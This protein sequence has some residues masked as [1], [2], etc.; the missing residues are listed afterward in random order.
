MN[1]NDL[2]LQIF[3]NLTDEEWDKIILWLQADPEFIC[4]QCG[5]EHAREVVDV[6]RYYDCFGNLVP[7]ED[8]TGTFSELQCKNDIDHNVFSAKTI[9][10]YYDELFE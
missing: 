7:E 2:T 4:I 8:T 6:Y 9:A 3:E 10:K 5:L 1:T